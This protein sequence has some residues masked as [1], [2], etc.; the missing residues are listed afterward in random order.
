MEAPFGRSIYIGPCGFTVSSI[1]FYSHQIN[2]A[3]FVVSVSDI[4]ESFI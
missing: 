4:Q 1:S 2:P 3:A